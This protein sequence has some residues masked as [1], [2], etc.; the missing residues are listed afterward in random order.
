MFDALRFLIAMRGGSVW[1]TLA[2]LSMRE[3]IYADQ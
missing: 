1:G 3:L 2:G